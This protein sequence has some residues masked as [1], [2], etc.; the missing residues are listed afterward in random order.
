[1]TSRHRSP[2][3]ERYQIRVRGHLGET[4]RSAFPALAHRT[5]AGDT[6]L[7]G[8][9]ADQAALYGVLA[10]L[11]AL[12]LELVEVRRIPPDGPKQTTSRVAGAAVSEHGEQAEGL[13]RL[14][15][16]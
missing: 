5:A 6:V 14:R 4:V 8:E 7:T 3:P 11:E 1:M 13:D 9:L 15:P 16:T 2:E 12:S 10:E